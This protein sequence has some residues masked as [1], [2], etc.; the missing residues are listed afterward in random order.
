[1]SDLL[2]CQLDEEQERRDSELFPRNLSKLF[3]SSNSNGA[4]TANGFAVARTGGVLDL[5]RMQVHAVNG[6][7]ECCHLTREP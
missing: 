2:Y 3:A 1:M 6:R 5:E 7:T 4:Q